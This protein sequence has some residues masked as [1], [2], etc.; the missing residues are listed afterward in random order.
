MT[1]CLLSALLITAAMLAFIKFSFYLIFSNHGWVQPIHYPITQRYKS[2]LPFIYNR[3]SWPRTKLGREPSFVNVLYELP[4][5]THTTNSQRP[6]DQMQVAN[7][8][9][10][11]TSSP[12]QRFEFNSPQVFFLTGIERFRI[13]GDRRI[14]LT[15]RFSPELEQK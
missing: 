11:R 13:L 4:L 15:P 12:S 10:I 1:S 7:N 3:Y 6:I 5:P 14:Q 2:I 9:D 8:S